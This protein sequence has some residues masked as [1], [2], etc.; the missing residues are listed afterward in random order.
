MIKIDALTLEA[1]VERAGREAPRS[2]AEKR[3]EEDARELLRDNFAAQ[4]PPAPLPLVDALA[5]EAD[6]YYQPT[7]FDPTPYE[8][9]SR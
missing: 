9:N 5:P 8:E 2:G 3:A 7:L 6:G 1:L 4:F